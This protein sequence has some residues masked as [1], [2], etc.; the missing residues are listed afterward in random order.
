MER[1]RNHFHSRAMHKVR[2]KYFWCAFDK[3]KSGCER[4]SVPLLLLFIVVNY[5]N[6]HSVENAWMMMMMKSSNTI[7][8]IERLRKSMQSASAYTH[9]FP[10][11]HTLLWFSIDFKLIHDYLI[12]LFMVYSSF[13]SFCWCS[14]SSTGEQISIFFTDLN[15]IKITLRCAW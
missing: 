5:L 13:F 15:M 8:V 12:I 11:T 1:V 9:A 10:H 7:E 3:Q 2:D 6:C 14:P 4:N